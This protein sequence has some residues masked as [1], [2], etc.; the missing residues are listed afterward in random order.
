M[1]A[2]S[3]SSGWDITEEQ[4]DVYRQRSKASSQAKAKALR[5]EGPSP[6]WIQ[7]SFQLKEFN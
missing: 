4:R 2:S 7:R 6:R 1:S 3:S 5:G